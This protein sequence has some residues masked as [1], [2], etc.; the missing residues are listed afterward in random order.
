MR[1]LFSLLTSIALVAVGF[2]AQ[3]WP[4]QPAQAAPPGSAFDPGLIISDSVFFDFGTLDQ[5][6]IQAVLD[7]KVSDCRAADPAVDC[8]KTYLSDIPETAATAEGD[9]G[10]CK[11]ITA[12]TGATAA[13][14]IYTIANACGIN[15][16]VLIVTLQKEQGLVTSTKPTEYMYRAAMGFGCPDSDPGICGK[17]YTGLFNQLYRA[18]KQFRWYGNPAGSFTYWKPG[19]TVAM[20]YNPKSS[21]G[22]KTFELKS[23]ATA[24]L[25]YYT[26]YTPNDAALNNLY[27]TGDTCSAYGNRN[28]W[29]FYHDWFGSPIGGGYLLKAAGT[30]T[31]LIVDKVKYRVSDTRLL[32]SLRPLGPLGEVSQAYLDSFQNAGDIYQL[33]KSVTSGAY[34]LVVDGLKYSFTDCSLAQQYGLSCDLATPL[35]DSQLMTFV[36][37]GT[38]SRLVTTSDGTKYWIENGTKRVVVDDLALA[39]VGAQDLSASPM[40][41]EQVTSLTA[42]NALASELALFAI[43]GTNDVALAS[44]G[45]TYRFVA[46]LDSAINLSQW[47]TKSKTSIELQAIAPTIAGDTIRGFVSGPDGKTYVLTAGGKVAVTDPE[48]WTDQIVALPSAV[49]NAIPDVQGALATPAVVTSA[50]NRYSYFV[51]GAERRIATSTAMTT[52]F[53][54]LIDQPKTIQLPQAAINQVSSVGT[55]FA[56]GSII[57]ANGTTTLY[58]VDDLTRKVQ[59]ASTAQATNVSDSKVF[60]FDKSDVNKLETR[61]GFS[62]IKV[63]CDGHTYLIDR[64]T[65]YPISP[66]AVQEFPGEP[67]PLATSTCASMKVSDR[68]VGQFLRDAKGVLYFVEGGKRSKISSWA[69]FATLR[70]DGPG[71]IQATNYFAAKIPISGKAPATVQLASLEGTPTPVFDEFTFIGAV[72]EVVAPKPAVTPTPTPTPTPTVTPSPS[73]TATAAAEQ[74]YKVVS[75]DTLNAIAAKFGVSAT[76]L[77]TY[78]NITDPRLLRIGQVLKIPGTASTATATPTQTPTPT[79]TPTPTVTAEPQPEVAAEVEYRVQSGDTLWSIASKFGLSMARLQEYNSISN[80]AYIRVGQLLKIPTSTSEVVAEAASTPTASATPEP[81]V[82]TYTIKSGDTLWGI[83]RKLGV[84]STALAELN[85]INNANYI[86][87]GQVLK[88]P[89]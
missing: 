60:S 43:T 6:Q 73:P 19:R 89:N 17:V 14:I 79:P 66:E 27:G 81:V 18:A 59:L 70:G 31:Y 3:P 29:R 57:K 30:E 5:A 85:N 52:R 50:G 65:L 84:S 41:I 48:N 44:G 33:V 86:R 13:E 78:N 62:S 8:L 61:T 69:H 55:G 11:A 87:V 1:R 83:A 88:V 15:P 67:Y 7:S 64:G 35:T 21:C 39:S 68:V 58:L 37:G 38:L 63:Q 9:V 56:P 4:T 47:F 25:Y 46:S 49:L 32:A 72:P 75:G 54:D 76:L 53:L 40:V 10:P 28:F 12:K 23:Q 77:Q 22:T 24:N 34:F 20:R 82:K 71:Y 45:K 74:T 36:D 16:K 80:A 51:E 2:V 26:P 42:G